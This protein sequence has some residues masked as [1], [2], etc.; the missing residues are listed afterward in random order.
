MQRQNPADPAIR[1]LLLLF[2]LGGLSQA[3]EPQVYRNF[4]PD[5]G[6]S[7][8]GVVLGPELALCYD[9]QRGGVNRVWRG[10]LDLSPTQR[11]KINAAAAI[12]GEVF[13]REATL[14]PLRVGSAEGT[15]ERRFK[16]YR[17]GKDAVI[18]E[19]TLDGVPVRETLRASPDG[20]GVV[21]EWSGTEG[22][23]LYF[24]AET[25]TDAVVSFTG[26]EEVRP[27]LWR[28][29]AG[30]G[31]VFVMRLQPKAKS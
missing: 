23:A 4:M 6:P 21:R 31:R 26:A 18:F 25:Q 20:R 19:F 8:F 10:S 5:A 30:E 11:A 12:V 9:P 17:Y 24:H 22:T 14:Q 29:Q 13:Y 1:L 16:G 2:V 27:G 7:A 15:P 3:A 28:H